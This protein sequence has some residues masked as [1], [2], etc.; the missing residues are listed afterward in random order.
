MSGRAGDELRKYP[1]GRAMTG[2]NDVRRGAGRIISSR[3]RP[4]EMSA[5]SDERS[6]NRSGPESDNV[7]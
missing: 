1:A 2:Q 7:R 4:E 3:P 6:K 5:Q